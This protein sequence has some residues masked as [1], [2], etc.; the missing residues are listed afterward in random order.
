MARGWESKGVEAQQD[1]ARERRG[2]I[3][4]TGGP[5][6]RGHEQTTLELALARARADLARA[7]HDAHKRSLE[8]A[9][10]ALVERI[11]HRER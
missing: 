9:I 5:V 10:A 4:S 3:G 8:A 1:A 7:T 6:S 11:E 2:S